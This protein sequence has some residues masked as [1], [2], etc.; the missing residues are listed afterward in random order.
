MSK[1]AIIL[2]AAG[3]SSRFGSP[4]QLAQNNGQSFIAH[5][6]SQALKVTKEMVV[7]LGANHDVIKKEIEKFSTYIAMNEKWEEGMSSSI[8][9]GME[10][11]LKYETCLN[12]IIIAVCDQPFLSSDVMNL[13]IEKYE[14]GGKPIIASAYNN[15]LGTPV[16]FDKTFFATLMELQGQAG[17]KKIIAQNKDVVDTVTFPLGGVDIDTKEDFEKLKTYTNIN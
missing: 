3:S 8:R 5:A 15:A 17:A 9:K 13:L 14:S 10:I 7:V 16:L 4:K 11:L 12:A 2:L 6:I 1:Y